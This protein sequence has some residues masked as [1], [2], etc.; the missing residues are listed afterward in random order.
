MLTGLEDVSGCGA[1][2]ASECPEQ[3]QAKDAEFIDTYADN[4]GLDSACLGVYAK[5]SPAMHE[6]TNADNSTVDV[7]QV[8]HTKHASGTHDNSQFGSCTKWPG[9]WAQRLAVFTYC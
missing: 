2:C 8:G 1:S 7:F 4:G 6:A 3:D 9:G 5:R